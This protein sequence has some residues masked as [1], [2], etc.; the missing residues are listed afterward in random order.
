MLVSQKGEKEFKKWLFDVRKVTK[1][2]PPFHDFLQ[3]LTDLQ[4]EVTVEIMHE[5]G[6]NMK[7]AWNMTWLN[8]QL[9]GILSETSVGKLSETVMGREKDVNTNG[10][11]IFRD[12]TRDVL[13]SSREGMVALGLRVVKP[14]KATIENFEE[15][16]RSWEEDVERYGRISGNEVNEDLKPVYL[17]D[18]MPETLK[19]RLDLEKHK[20]RK[21]P[22]LIEFF[23]RM[24][25]EHKSSK[26]MERPHIE[27]VNELQQSLA[28]PLGTGS[29]DESEGNFWYELLLYAKESDVEKAL[30]PEELLTFQRWKTKGGG[31]GGPAGNRWPQLFGKGGGNVSVGTAS[32]SGTSA[33]SGNS[34]VFEGECS[35]CGGKGHRKQFA[36]CC[37]R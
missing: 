37:T 20:W 24:I 22:D 1:D 29:R 13:D 3:W 27:G 25:L 2:D 5:K 8:E 35:H 30:G 28:E 34:E 4:E 7:G 14:A 36:Q 33:T 26:A 10:A 23:E 19:L 32:T 16:L 11:R 15:R 31:K 17:Q 12:L 21:F 18:L 9:Y 6:I